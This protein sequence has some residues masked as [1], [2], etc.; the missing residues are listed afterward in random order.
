MS[1]SRSMEHI[2]YTLQLLLTKLKI[3]PIIEPL[4]KNI[5]RAYKLLLIGD[6]D[7]K[8]LL[9]RNFPLDW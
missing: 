9:H 4:T 7:E 5:Q 6:V 2:F 8:L 1:N 3:H